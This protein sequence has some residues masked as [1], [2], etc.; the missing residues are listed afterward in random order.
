MANPTLSD[1]AQEFVRWNEE[2]I[3]PQQPADNDERVMSIATLAL[4]LARS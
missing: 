1:L 3:F 4:N 2:R